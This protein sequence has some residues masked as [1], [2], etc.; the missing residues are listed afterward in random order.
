MPQEPQI[1]GMPARHRKIFFWTLVLVFVLLLPTMIFYTTG[2]RL[3]FDNDA[4]TTM[5]TTTGGMYITTANLEV[6]VYLDE[7]QIERPRLFRNAYYI[8]NIESGVTS[9]AF[10]L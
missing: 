10:A 2:Y 9:R 7:E 6:D 8:Q 4:D 3:S 1:S 5:V